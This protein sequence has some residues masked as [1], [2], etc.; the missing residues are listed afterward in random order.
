MTAGLCSHICIE[1][2]P[3]ASMN[4]SVHVRSFC[5]VFRG[6][7]YTVIKLT[8]KTEAVTRAVMHRGSVARS[9]RYGGCSPKEGISY[10]VV[11]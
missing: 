8:D 10:K 7:F 2:K 5:G 9:R 3:V 6:D 4:T 11:K 1:Y